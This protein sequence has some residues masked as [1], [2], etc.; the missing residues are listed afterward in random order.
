MGSPF[1]SVRL[2][3]GLLIR[4]KKTVFSN[5]GIQPL[6]RIV[7]RGVKEI[8]LKSIALCQRRFKSWT[9]QTEGKG[10]DVVSEWLRRWTA[11]PLGFARAG[12]NPVDIVFLSR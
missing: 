6:Y 9:M 1:R 4:Q 5:F 7:V 2:S 8:D 3:S 12:S 10:R 11:N